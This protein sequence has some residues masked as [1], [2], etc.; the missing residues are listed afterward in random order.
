MEVVMTGT[1][2]L[3]VAL[4]VLAGLA[5]MSAAPAMASQARPDQRSDDRGGYRGDWDRRAA[6]RFDLAFRNGE[7]DGY[8]EGL[9]DGERG[10]RFDPV[11]ER[12]YRAGDSGYD[13]RYG[14]R[15]LYKDRYRDAF[16]RGYE[17]GYQDGRRYDRRNPSRGWWPF[18]R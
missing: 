10:D 16:R 11:R 18:G 17:R 7:E 1:R 2:V 3:R 8:K 9:H 14:S 15:E 4:L 12:R 5:I 6:P 13:R